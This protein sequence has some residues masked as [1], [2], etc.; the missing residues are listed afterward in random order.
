M[1]RLSASDYESVLAFLEQAHA[2]EGQAP[3]GTGLLDRLAELV[4][5]DHTAFFELDHDRRVLSERVTSSGMQQPWNGMPD[6]VWTLPRTVELHRRKLASGVG[7][8]V[9]SEIFDRRLRLRPDWNPN[10]RASG[11]VDEIH[12]DLDPPRRWK[13]QLAVFGIRDFGPRER[14]ILSLVR[15]HLGVVYRRARL[16]RRLASLAGAIEE[17]AA[18]EL[19][20]REREVMHCVGEGLSDAEIARRLVVERSTVRKHLEHVYAK[21]GV[22]SR[23]A[24][25]AKLRR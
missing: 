25:L 11:V 19:T 18:A 21:L 3:F 7:P 8:A 6:E 5:C 9:L 2:T 20:A 10:L 22:R 1:T 17:R 23:T 14:R 15:P 12:V 24:A 13:T 4:R 16:R